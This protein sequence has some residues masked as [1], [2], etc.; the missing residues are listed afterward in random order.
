L[1]RK[2]GFVKDEGFADVFRLLVKDKMYPGVEGLEFSIQFPRDFI[3][4][5][6]DD[7]L[8]NFNGFFTRNIRCWLKYQD[9]G[10]NYGCR[11]LYNDSLTRYVC[12][13]IGNLTDYEEA[14]K[15]LTLLKKGINMY[16]SWYYGTMPFGDI[17]QVSSSRYFGDSKPTIVDVMMVLVNSHY[18]SK[19]KEEIRDISLHP[20]NVFDWHFDEES[21]DRILSNISR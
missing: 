5:N 20:D 9:S 21:K 16:Y 2:Y 18:L 15:V 11:D 7:F 1:D 13:E 12:Q 3:Y 10:T 19:Y 6:L 14:V 4:W 8:E 17:E